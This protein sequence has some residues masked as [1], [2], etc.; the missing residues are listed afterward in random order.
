MVEAKRPREPFWRGR[1]VLLTGHTG[2]KGAWLSLWLQRL[3]ARV[4]GLSDGVPTTPSLHEIAHAGDGVVHRSVD[5][6]DAAAV[7]AAVA[8][9]EPSVLLHLAA[10]PL[11]RRSYEQPEETFAI[12]V[13]GT[14]NVLEAARG[15]G[16]VDAIIVVTSDKCYLPGPDPHPEDDPL[17]GEDP[18]SASKAAAELVAAAY[19]TSFGL[20]VA[21]GRAGNVIGGGDWGVDRLV[22]DVLRALLAGEPIEIRNPSAVRPWQHV[23]NPLDGYLALAQ[24]VAEDAATFA[25]AWNF[26]PERDDE[27]PVSAIAERLA[28]LWGGGARIAG[29]PGEHPHESAVLRISSAKAHAELGWRPAWDLDAAL[30]AI[31]DWYRAYERGEDLRAVTLAQIEAYEGAAASG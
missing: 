15:A 22:P 30:R 19:R 31:V 6:R 23:L 4:T 5:V 27:Q 10:Q 29:Q 3:G 8:E 9:A 24:A 17:G 12:N 13:Q 2:F 26:G 28:A 21:S 18:Y 7:R 11:V 1:N 20:P 16:G 14:V 25:G